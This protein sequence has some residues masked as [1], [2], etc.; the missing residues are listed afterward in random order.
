MENVDAMPIS[1]KDKQPYDQW[2][3]LEW[4]PSDIASM[5]VRHFLPNSTQLG[6]ALVVSRF[7]SSLEAGCCPSLFNSIFLWALHLSRAEDLS[8]HEEIYLQRALTAF[9]DFFRAAEQ[10]ASDKVLFDQLSL[11]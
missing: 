10:R 5:L 8:N 2:W 7:L 6:F 1:Q 4:P 3:Q 9:R 11:W